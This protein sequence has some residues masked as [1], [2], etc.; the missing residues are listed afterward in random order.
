MLPVTGTQSLSKGVPDQGHGGAVSEGLVPW[1]WEGGPG[2][3][4]L[5]GAFV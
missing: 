2:D 1:G 5:S 4:G 3:T